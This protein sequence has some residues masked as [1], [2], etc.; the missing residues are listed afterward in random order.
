MPQQPSRLFYDSEF[1]GLHQH[2]TLISL[3]LVSEEGPEFYAEFS[4]Y[5]KEQCDDWIMQHV[6][7]HTGLMQTMSVNTVRQ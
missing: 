5:A 2:T 1:T 7:G 3:A 4:D 6:I